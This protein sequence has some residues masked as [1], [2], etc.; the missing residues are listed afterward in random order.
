MTTV[1]R[2]PPEPPMVLPADFGLN[3]VTAFTTLRCGGSS[4]ARYRGFNLGD[5]VGD[6]PGSVAANRFALGRLLP[7]GAEVHWL[8]QVHGTSVLACHNKVSPHHPVADASW[9]NIRGHVSVVLT[10]D[11]LPIVLASPNGVAV[12][13]GGWR[14]LAGGVL[15]ATI[16]AL[17]HSDTGWRAWLGPAIGACCFEVG[18]DVCEAFAAADDPAVAAC[19]TPAI[20]KNKYWGD[21][22][23]LARLRL[24]RLGIEQITG[25]GLCTACDAQRFYSHRRDGLTGRMA[26]VAFLSPG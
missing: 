21:L 4:T 19:L 8:Q 11:C 7:N 15:E 10:A 16:A 5:H 12:V 20:Q 6:D 14:G 26:T 25:G 3:G 23:A 22:F 24:Q 2:E 18:P 17:P 1:S 9:T 13:H